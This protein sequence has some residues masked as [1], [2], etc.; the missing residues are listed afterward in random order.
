VRIVL[1][2]VTAARVTVDGQIV[3][4]I[5]G[6]VVALVGV[7]HTDTAADAERLAD[8]T[9]SLRLFADRERP[10]DRTLADVGGAVLCVSQFTL[11]GDVRRGNRPSWVQAAAA[12][13]ARQLVDAY[14]ARLRYH[15]LVVSNGVFGAHMHIALDNDGPVTLILDTEELARPRRRTATEDHAA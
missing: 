2:R 1:Q 3:G 4:E 9:A 12:E 13:P 6:G 5:G 15:E 10:F 11:F 7:T 14:A 8:K